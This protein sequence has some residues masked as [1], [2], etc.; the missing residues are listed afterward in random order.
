VSQAAYGP[1][2]SD[3]LVVDAN[4]IL[5]LVL[6]LPYSQQVASKMA[7]WERAGASLLAPLL[8]EY[9]IL[10]ALR[11]ATALGTL[12]ADLAGEALRQ[13]ADLHVE[14][15]PPTL[16]LHER[17]LLWAARLDQKVAYDAQYVALADELGV[18]LWTADRR[19]VSAARREGVPWVH[20]IGEGD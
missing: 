6:P 3:A 15:L 17:A 1:I 11:K 13:I 20:W 9:E 8:L 16:P 12:T 18:E 19:L 10:S 14:T 4:L 5:A 2:Q 7:A